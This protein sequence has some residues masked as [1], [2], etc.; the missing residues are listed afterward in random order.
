VVETW[1]RYR[2]RVL[3]PAAGALTYLVSFATIGAIWLKHTVLTEYLAGATA[4]LIR[5]NMLLLLVE[6]FLPFP[7]RLVAEH[8]HAADAERVAT[9]VYGVN[10]P[11][12]SVLTAVLW[13][14]AGH[15]P[16]RR[17]PAVCVAPC[18]R[19]LEPADSAGKSAEVWWRSRCWPSGSGRGSTG[20][21]VAGDRCECPRHRRW[22]AREHRSRPAAPAVMS[23]PRARSAAPSMGAVRLST[24]V[25]AGVLD[26]QHV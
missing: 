15:T 18:S 20:M 14:Y 6:S 11:L 21:Y 3:Q 17:P 10:L 19:V 8:I 12:A 7:T 13:R 2:E 5:L 1:L 16:P 22:R 25:G 9:T 24:L 4:V 23:S 26:A